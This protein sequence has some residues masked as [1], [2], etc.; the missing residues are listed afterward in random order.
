MSTP[1][2]PQER[3]TA[4]TRRRASG[5]R[6]SG[7]PGTQSR[8]ALPVARSE[9]RAP[10]RCAWSAS[11][12]DHA[13]GEG[14]TGRTCQ[15][16][17][18]AWLTTECAPQHEQEHDCQNHKVHSRRL[19]DPSRVR[20]ASSFRKSIAGERST[21]KAARPEARCALAPPLRIQ[22]VPGRLKETPR[23]GLSRAASCLHSARSIKR[24]GPGTPRRSPARPARPRRRRCDRDDGSRSRGASR[25]RDKQPASYRA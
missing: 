1:N 22:V 2:F 23:F 8:H 10:R 11:W 14:V 21:V 5:L 15:L 4:S 24:G 7:R 17:S 25:D 16:C 13:E 9:P 6:P 18:R 12:S 3:A 20:A 19:L